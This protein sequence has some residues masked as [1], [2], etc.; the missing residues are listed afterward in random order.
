VQR[1]PDLLRQFFQSPTTSVISLSKKTLLHN[2]TKIIS[3]KLPRL[4]Q[5]TSRIWKPRLGA[6]AMNLDKTVQEG[7]QPNDASAHQATLLSE[8]NNSAAMMDDDIL[9]IPQVETPPID[10]LVNQYITPALENTPV[11]ADSIPFLHAVVTPTVVFPENEL[12]V[13]EGK[14]THAFIGND[15]ED[16]AMGVEDDGFD[17]FPGSTNDDGFVGIEGNDHLTDESETGLK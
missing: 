13:D 16:I 2:S 10:T 14:L 3:L 8:V 12:T 1:P 11:C 5:A 17:D 15:L 7:T 9:L 6:D 4:S